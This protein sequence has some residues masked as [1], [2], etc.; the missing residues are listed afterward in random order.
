MS[1]HHRLREGPHH[2]GVYMKK[3]I[4][5]L[6]LVA[7]LVGVL[8]FGLT[9]C[10][11]S[12]AGFTPV[13]AQADIFNELNSKTADVGILD[14]TMAKY[15]ISQQT[16]LTQNIA[17]I[18][19]IEFEEEQYGVAFRKGSTGLADR[20]NKILNEQKDTGVKAIAEKYGLENNVLSLAY[21]APKSTDDTDWNYI[22]SKG[23]FIIGYTLNPPMAIKNSDGSLSGF[24]IELPT[25]VV[26]WLNEKYGTSIE[27]KFQ[28]INWD[29]KEIE[30]ESKNIDCIWNGMTITPE[31]EAAMTISI[32]YLLNKQVAITLKSNVEQFNTLEKLKSAR[33][34]AEKGSAGEEIAQSIFA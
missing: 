10:D 4:I 14:Y 13:D 18:D 32:P 20:I 17:I 19:S 25:Q 27:I 16:T 26:N 31:R 7:A 1:S 23:T 34:V 30:L 9:A 22:V 29:N 15:L 11:K 24:D 3:V 8:A 6:V 12:Q 28:L 21:T 2:K 33:I 5:A